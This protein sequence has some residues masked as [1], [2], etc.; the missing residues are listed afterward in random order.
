MPD[1]VSTLV[2]RDAEIQSEHGCLLAQICQDTGKE[3]EVQV[4]Y[5]KG[6][7]AHIGPSRAEVS[8]RRQ[9]KSQ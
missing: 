6:L 5:D 4:F 2:V 7:A 3:E 9:T 8:A 1:N